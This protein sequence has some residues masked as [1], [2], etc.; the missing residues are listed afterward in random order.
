[1]SDFETPSVGVTGRLVGTDLMQRSVDN[2]NTMLSSLA[3]TLS[4]ILPVLDAAKEGHTAGK[5]G[6]SGI[7]KMTSGGIAGNPTFNGDS[8]DST[9]A[10]PS[11][12]GFGTPQSAPYEGAGKRRAEGP[13]NTMPWA[14]GGS[15]G[16]SGDSGGYGGG[17]GGGGSHRA[18]GSGWGGGTSNIAMGVGLGTA[19]MGVGQKIDNN[20]GIPLGTAT[21]QSHQMVNVYGAYRTAGANDIQGFFSG[22]GPTAL[23][24]EDWMGQSV[25][26]LRSGFQQGTPEFD[27]WQK[28]IEVNS[29]VN[30]MLSATGSAQMEA[31]WHNPSTFNA[32]RAYGG[33]K[34]MDGGH[35]KSTQEIANEILGLMDLSGGTQKH[36]PEQIAW[37]VYGADS[38]LNGQLIDM[39]MRGA[40]TPEAM[41]EIKEA[42]HD[43][44]V[45]RANDMDPETLT[46]TMSSAVR[47]DKR[48]RRDL[49]DM[50]L[51]DQQHDDKVTEAEKRDGNVQRLE[52]YADSLEDTTQGLKDFHEALNKVTETIPL[53]NEVRGGYQNFKE[54]PTGFLLS[55]LTT[56]GFGPAG[57]FGDFFKNLMGF[58]DGGVLPGPRAT[59]RD[60]MSF[61]SPEHG[62]L[63]L[64]G[65]E[66]IM[67]P[68]WVDEIGGPEKV[69]EMN[70]KAREGKG[71]SLFDSP[72]NN[73]EMSFFQG[74]TMPASGTA[75]QHTSGY[76]WA[77]WAGDI[78]EPGS[79]D[80]GNT[81][82]AWKKGVVTSVQKLQDS[83]G[84]HVR[85]H[86][87][88]AKQESLYAHLSEIGVKVGDYV[89]SGVPI[90]KVGSTGNSTGPHLH[91][92]YKPA[93]GED[94]PTGNG[95][96]NAPSTHA[97]DQSPGSSSG[98]GSS[99]AGSDDEPE[100]VEEGTVGSAW[101]GT[102]SP[103]GGTSEASIFAAALAGAGGGAGMLGESSEEEEGTSDSGE[104]EG[105][106]ENWEDPYPPDGGATEPDTTSGG[107]G[108]GGGGTSEQN[109]ALG[110][111]MAAA[112]GWT[113]KQWDAL[114]QL[115]TKESGWRTDADNPTSSAYGI[116]QA[117]VGTHKDSLGSDYYGKVVSGSWSK[118]ASLNFSG[119]N[120]RT[121]IKWGLNYIK[122]RYGD[123][124]KAWAFHQK[125]NWYDKGAWE[126]VQDEDARVHQGEMIIPA[127]P[128]AQIRD[129]LMH[130]QDYKEKARQQEH[131]IGGAAGDG[132]VLKFEQGSIQIHLGAGVSPQTGRALGR[133]FVDSVVQDRRIK[134]LQNGK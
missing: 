46:K 103:V 14:A 37:F 5:D 94:D 9:E 51:W 19:V 42:I 66:A 49:E 105:G 57:G 90:G 52:S 115:W 43:I 25:Q 22:G 109:K 132:V 77:T 27:A 16:G 91:F 70:L 15:G 85:I 18:P 106:W 32:M 114:L 99:G 36:T 34:T 29:V 31:S 118:P 59:S 12:G 6:F 95:G 102:G 75:K 121:Q 128:A 24:H 30:P 65:G 100:E 86:H 35:K 84:W 122:G 133:E 11:S 79:G 104:P 126:I 72:S 83:Y 21:E 17:G 130:G 13:A 97:E 26:M 50:G 53:L 45:A 110:K 47:G 120:P 116:P 80:Y 88:W 38:P 131:G 108:G 39:V 74:G 89:G 129:I 96:G 55:R 10:R 56:G 107:G 7:R 20:V 68:E 73:R 61:F 3:S 58:A 62:Q 44:L 67:V 125:N 93:S 28:N 69:D 123:P 124:A 64:A 87:G 134:E 4:G 8:W 78:N 71:P 1:M 63:N 41:P 40:M 117:L 82:K 76:P 113:G 54:D 60:N 81:V 92:E 2:V 111:T 127:A 112:Y 23:N 33:I 119:G 98:N 101:A 48:A